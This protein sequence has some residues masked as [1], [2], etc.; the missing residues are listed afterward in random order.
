MTIEFGWWILPLAV[1]IT[2]FVIAY[3][4][5]PETRP[6]NYLPDVVS[7]MIGFGMTLVAAIVSLVAWLVWALAT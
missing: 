2:A 4:A 3:R 1:T 7:P 5:S 6:S